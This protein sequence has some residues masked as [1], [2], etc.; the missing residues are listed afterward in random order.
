M[1]D[2]FV[3]EAEN[4]PAEGFDLALAN[5]VVAGL[6]VVIMDAAVE[7]DDEAGLLAG[8]VGEV[9]ADRVLAA[10]LQAIEATAT[11]SL[12]ELAFG[13]GLALAEVARPFGSSL[14]VHGS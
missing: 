1:D 8:E 3:Q 6:I 11:E 10:E 12:P 2:L 7:F 9:A 4:E 14:A 5:E 13:I